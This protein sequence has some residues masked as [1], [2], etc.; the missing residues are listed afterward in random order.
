MALKVGDKLPDFKTV[1]QLGNPISS[2]DLLG[3]KMYCTFTPK[4]TLQVVHSRLV[5]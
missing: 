3:K 1:D 2:E 4:M 5:I